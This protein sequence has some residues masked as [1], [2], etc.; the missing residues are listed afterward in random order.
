MSREDIAIILT[1]TFVAWLFY[2]IGQL[3]GQRDEYQR[4][5][6]NKRRD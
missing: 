4:L 5:T 3:K 2:R 1:V 6:K